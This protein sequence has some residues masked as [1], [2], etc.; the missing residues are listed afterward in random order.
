MSTNHRGNRTA[1]RA[2]LV[3]AAALTLVGLGANAPASAD[4]GSFGQAV[5]TCASMML[6]G[7][8]GPRGSI[9]MTMPDGSTMA[10]RNFGQ[11]VTSMRT[12]QMC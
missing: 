6:P 2:G 11:M 7:D 5:R 1:A 12:Q 8:L 4:T 9:S 3:A 10:W